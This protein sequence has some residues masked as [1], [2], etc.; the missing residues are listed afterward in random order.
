MFQR[1]LF[2]MI[3]SLFSMNLAFGIERDNCYKI[4][5]QE[6]ANVKMVACILNVPSKSDEVAFVSFDLRNGVKND[7]FCG[8]GGLELVKDDSGP[9][10]QAVKGDDGKFAYFNQTKKTAT[11]EEGSFV[12]IAQQAEIGGKYSTMPPNEVREY[13]K[14]AQKRAQNFCH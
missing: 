11:T 9:N 10:V 7:S 1:P 12:L 13:V 8:S 2:V 6:D 4:D 5:F 3:V 14:A